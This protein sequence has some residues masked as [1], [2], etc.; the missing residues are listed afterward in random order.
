[1]AT[2][3]KVTNGNL[4]L[5][6]GS[7]VGKVQEATLME[8]TAKMSEFNALGMV[9]TTEYASGFEMMEMTTVLHAYDGA[10]L[11]QLADP[12]TRHR[13]Q[14]RCQIDDYSSGGVQQQ[15]PCA[16]YATVSAKKLPFGAFQAHERVTQEITWAVYYCRMEI[17]GAPIV[18][19][20]P[21][22]NIYK[23]GGVDKLAAFR[24]N[25]GL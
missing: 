8:V 5:D 18:E 15:L 3:R 6:G 7:L 13:I 17:N 12:N 25:L 24:A 20:D 9:G 22:A 10:L 16:M 23:V 21:V 1:M 11:T 14:M 4:Y 2:V 19:F